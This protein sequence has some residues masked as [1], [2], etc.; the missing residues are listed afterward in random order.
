MGIIFKEEESDSGLRPPQGQSRF[1]N[2]WGLS[3]CTF[4][5]R[6]CRGI[7]SGG[8]RKADT[9]LRL[10]GARSRF[11]GP[12]GSFSMYVCGLGDVRALFWR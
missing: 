7:V 12:I 6:G 9:L 3:L 2:R 1:W 4:V 10:R 11:E 5:W 8:E